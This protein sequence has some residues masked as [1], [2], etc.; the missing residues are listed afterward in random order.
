[1]HPE[2]FP[3]RFADIREVR[4]TVV[5]THC[6][7]W[8]E[9]SIEVQFDQVGVLDQ[10]WGGGHCHVEWVI[11]AQQIEV[12]GELGLLRHHLVK[13]SDL[14]V[15]KLAELWHQLVHDFVDTLA[16]EVKELGEVLV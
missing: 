1:M 14:R 8:V 16:K 9:T 11:L 12:P 2:L 15:D 7:S 10:A 6:L 4:V 3:V 13:S 5:A